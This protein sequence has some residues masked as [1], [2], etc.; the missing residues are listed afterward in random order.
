MSGCCFLIRR[1]LWRAL[2]GFSEDFDQLDTGW[3]ASCEDADLAWRAQLM[4]YRIV[5]CPRSVMY[6]KYTSKGMI[7]P[8]FCSYEW[9][10]S[11]FLLRNLQ[12][13]TLFILLPILAALEAGA[14]FYALV[15]GRPWLVA[16]VRIA[17]WL[18][19]HGGQVREM[20]SR[21]QKTRKVGDRAIMRRMS[22]RIRLAHVM[23]PG[24]LTRFLQWGLDGGFG[25]YYHLALLGLA[26][27]DRGSTLWGER[28]G[29]SRRVGLLIKRAF[30]ILFS[31]A[32]L[33]LLSP[34]MGAIALAVRVTLGQPVLFRQERPGLHERP[35]TLLKFRTMT[36][37]R[38]ERGVLLSDAERVTGLGRFLR[39]TSLDELPE[40]INV[41][42]GE[43]SLV[44]PRP[45]LMSYLPHYTPTQRRRHEVRPGI[46]G[47]AQING[48]NALAWEQRFALDVWYVDHRSIG[49]DLKIIALTFWKVI[50]REG[51]NEEGSMTEFTGSTQSL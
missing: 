15:K 5:Y 3:H 46:T 11:L 36:D 19:T 2:G 9:G 33:I 26:L 27:L 25:V 7:P 50:K 49:L 34:L 47:L 10:R 14:W 37:A 12:L 32:A 28:R 41:L 48:R 38:D 23:R 35:F 17:H 31:L 4:G 42:R 6:H 20:R 18:L 21:V 13:R 24:R 45:L 44:G 39:S 16:K 29:L 43:M 51:I 1:D 40:L 30:D 8:R 22:C